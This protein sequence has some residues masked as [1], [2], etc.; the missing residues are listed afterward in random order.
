MENRTMNISTYKDKGNLDYRL[1]KAVL[2]QLG[3]LGDDEPADETS[4]EDIANHGI[5][6]GFSGF[7]YY[8]DTAQFYADN[9]E[10]IRDQLK[11]EAES[12]GSGS[13]ISLIMSFNCIDGETTEDEVGETL[14]SLNHDQQVANCLAWYAAETVARDYMDIKEE[15]K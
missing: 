2:D 13:A 15:A 7:V 8:A 4:L 9:Q 6:G 5:N 11:E 1:I 10:L 14:Y 3:M 12:Y